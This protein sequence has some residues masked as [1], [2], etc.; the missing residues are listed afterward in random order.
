MLMVLPTIT[1]CLSNKTL[2]FNVYNNSVFGRC[3]SD[4]GIC[5]HML[6]VSIQDAG[7][8]QFGATT[9]SS[10]GMIY[11]ADSLEDNFQHAQFHQRFL[12]GIKFV[13][14]SW[15]LFASIRA[16]RGKHGLRLDFC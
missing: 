13:V 9:C 1:F 5:N 4:V 16:K 11:S 8:K 3:T 15:G 10:C 14:S 6:A 7:Q 2:L 12:D